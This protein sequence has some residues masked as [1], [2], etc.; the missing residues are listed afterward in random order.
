M[1]EAL[2]FVSDLVSLLRLRAAQQ[3]ERTAYVFLADGESESVRLSYAELDQEVRALVGQIQRVAANG[4]RALLLYLPGL[5]YIKAFFACLYAGVVAV[6]A[7]PPARRHPPRLA[8][9]VRDA[10]PVLVLTTTDLEAR[11]CAHTAG[12]GELEQLYCL[13]TD[14]SP[15]AA[16][17][18]WTPRPIGPDHLAFL[19]YTSGSTGDPKGVMVTHGNLLANERAIQQRFGHTQD[20]IV[21]GWVLSTTTWV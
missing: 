8:P 12:N 5:E 15:S 21:V 1:P 10:A 18:D 6:P 16:P 20:S 19:Q 11:L 14:A 3:G 2:H 13:A 9:I 7:H 17:A 4:A